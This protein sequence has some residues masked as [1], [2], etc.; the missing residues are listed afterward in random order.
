[1]IIQFI[2]YDNW[3][4]QNLQHGNHDYPE[5]NEPHEDIDPA[6]VVS[7]AVMKAAVELEE[8][9]FSGDK[10]RAEY[11]VEMLGQDLLK[12]ILEAGL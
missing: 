10:S 4:E 6:G 8:K 1:M 3:H 12:L 5:Q 7:G 9:E 2:Q 11:I